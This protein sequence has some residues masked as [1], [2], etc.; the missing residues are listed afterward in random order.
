MK[1]RKN[2]GESFRGSKVCLLKMGSSFYGSGLC[3]WKGHPDLISIFKQLW[4]WGWGDSLLSASFSSR[5]GLFLPFPSN[6]DGQLKALLALY[7]LFRVLDFSPAPALIL[8]INPQGLG[9][10]ARK[11]I[12]G[13]KWRQTSISQVNYS[14]KIFLFLDFSSSS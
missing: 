1:E 3:C 12:T 14:S 10:L 7:L 2:D 4:R 5:T 9:F 6:I 11:C 8:I 13:K